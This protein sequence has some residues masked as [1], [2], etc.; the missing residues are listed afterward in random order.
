MKTVLASRT[1]E[2]PDDGKL[3]RS[4]ES[5]CLFGLKLRMLESHLFSFNVLQSRL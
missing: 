5:L 3:R 4:L 1:V 2:I